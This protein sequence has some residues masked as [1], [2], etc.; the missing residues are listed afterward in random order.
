MKNLLER[1]EIE[2]RLL[3]ALVVATEE[4]RMALAAGDID[5]IVR[6]TERKTNILK[7]HE[8][9]EIS[10][11]HLIQRIPGGEA[12][13]QGD[14][15]LRDF[16]DE[17]ANGALRTQL[18]D[19]LTRIREHGGRLNK[20]NSSNTVLMRRALDWTSRLRAALTGDA[21]ASGSIYTKRGLYRSRGPGGSVVRG[22]A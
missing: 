4:E 17:N 18:L 13:V 12:V 11:E 8:S 1:L 3:E 16:V 2:S 21:A 9:L 6:C 14:T 7:A 15:T 22:R 10:R 5:R 20:L 19:T